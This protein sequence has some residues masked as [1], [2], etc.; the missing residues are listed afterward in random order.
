MSVP[1]EAAPVNYAASILLVDVKDL[2]A[3]Q[4]RECYTN[5]QRQ[6]ETLTEDTDEQFIALCFIIIVELRMDIE[7]IER[8]RGNSVEEF[9]KHKTFLKSCR[10]EMAKIHTDMSTRYDEVRV[11]KFRA[12]CRVLALEAHEISDSVEEWLRSNHAN[13]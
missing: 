7:N 11:K 6:S 10:R 4:M 2:T 12:A 9:G 13:A 1:A 5:L 3:D 8:E